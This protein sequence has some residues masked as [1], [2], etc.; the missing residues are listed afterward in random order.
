MAMV[1]TSTTMTPRC[2]SDAAEI[3]YG[4]QLQFLYRK[5][6][7]FTLRDAVCELGEYGF[8]RGIVACVFNEFPE[9]LDYLFPVIVADLRS[10]TA[11]HAQDLLVWKYMRQGK[12][13][14]ALAHSESI[15][16]IS[17]G[18]KRRHSLLK[19]LARWPEQSVGRH[20]ASA[21]C[22][23]M[24]EGSMFIP[25]T[26]NGL[27]AN[28]MIDSGATI[29]MITQSMARQL[30]LPIHAVP[31]EATGIYGATGVETAF[32]IAIAA[33]LDIG[34]CRLLNV[35]FLVLEDEHFQFPPAYAGALGLPV[36]VA[37][38]TLS[39]NRT[40]EFRFAFPAQPRDI[41]KANICFDGPE[42]L[43]NVVF[44]HRKLPLVL[45]TGSS[46]TIFGPT[47]VTR[48][49][50]LVDLER[51]STVLVRGVSGSAEIASVCLP[52][53]ALHVG[54]FS[55]AVHSAHML[56]ST[57][58]PNSNWLCGRLGIDYLNQAD[59]VTLDFHCMT[60]T[61]EKDENVSRSS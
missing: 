2:L 27:T 25:T 40:G 29:S 30:G 20:H 22:Y 21:L 23:E 53:M 31:P 7:W 42:P 28:F 61:L 6:D 19:T 37:L 39:W 46:S 41:Q 34:E 52:G 54:G 33:R 32:H 18:E 10:H 44:H 1:K 49:P 13:R 24:L 5:H 38:R 12:F 59:K 4:K 51:K 9:C 36:L 56:L 57:T 8:F 26:V 58:T 35:T 16:A 45:D 14:S 15:V 3:N 11:H 48:F 47:L 43:I 60:V 50:D 17:S 55:T